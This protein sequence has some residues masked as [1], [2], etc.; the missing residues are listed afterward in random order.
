MV[1]LPEGTEE[2]AMMTLH[3]ARELSKYAYNITLSVGEILPGTE[4]VDIA[5]EKGILPADFSW[6]EERF[7]HDLTDLGPA[8]VP[9]Y[10]EHLSVE[11]IRQ[12]KKEFEQIRFGRY[13]GYKDFLRMA[14]K[15]IRRIPSQPFSQTVKD[16]A[17][18]GK[19]IWSRIVRR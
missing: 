12:F 8:N 19:G 3:M 2:D 15:G 6:F 4:M 1:S 7:H 14:R 5:R 18:Y 11:F 16:A 9:L 10:L 17:R 13:T